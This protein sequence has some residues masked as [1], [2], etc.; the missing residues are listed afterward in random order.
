M[1]NERPA[2]GDLVL[3]SPPP[4]MVDWQT[5]CVILMSRFLALGARSVTITDEDVKGMATAGDY[6]PTGP[7]LAVRP[8]APGSLTISLHTRAEAEEIA[9]QYDAERAMAANDPASMAPTSG[10]V[11]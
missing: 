2:E 4:M 6:A 8:T 7:V 10:Q 5:V 11:Q 9:R 1:D 3:A